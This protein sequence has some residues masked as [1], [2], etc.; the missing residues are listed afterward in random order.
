MDNEFPV[1][2]VFRFGTKL[3][4]GLGIVFYGNKDNMS[5]FLQNP[6]ASVTQP[7]TKFLVFSFFWDTYFHSLPLR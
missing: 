2:D 1:P 3:S 4:P 5:G 6:V 7:H